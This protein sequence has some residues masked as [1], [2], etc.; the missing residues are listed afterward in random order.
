V[1]TKIRSSSRTKEDI[2]QDV[3]TSLRALE[4]D[5]IDV[6]QLHNSQA[7]SGSSSP[8]CAKPSQLRRRQGAILRRDDHTNETSGQR[9]CRRQGQILR[10]GPR[11]I[12]LQERRR[13]E[14]SDR[15][16]R[17]GRIGIV[18]MKTRQADTRPTRWAP[19][20]RTRRPSVGYSR[21]EY[22]RGPFRHEGHGPSQGGHR[23][24]GDA[25]HPR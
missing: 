12:Q 21:Q 23:R 4:T 3:E 10:H 5:Y 13:A 20:A 22:H 6:V 7:A 11:E 16:G 2:I 24:H 9:P 1:A 19:S 8:R 15:Q 18:A 14:K 25:P 17:A